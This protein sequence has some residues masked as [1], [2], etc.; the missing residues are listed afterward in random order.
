MYNQATDSPAID[1][2]SFRYLFPE[3]AR[4]STW[5]LDNWESQHQ[6]PDIMKKQADED[7][8]H[9][10]EQ[11]MM[12]KNTSQDLH[13]RLIMALFQTHFPASITPRTMYGLHSAY[14][15]PRSYYQLQFLLHREQ[16]GV[17]HLQHINMENWNLCTTTPEEQ[18]L[19]QLPN[20]D[21]LIIKTNFAIYNKLYNLFRKSIYALEVG[22]FFSSF[23]HSAKLYGLECQFRVLNNHFVIFFQ[24]NNQLNDVSESLNEWMDIG[25]KR[26]SGHF[27]YGLF[28][29]KFELTEKLVSEVGLQIQQAIDKVQQ[30]HPCIADIPISLKACFREFGS[31]SAGLYQLADGQF[32]HLDSGEYVDQAASTYSYDNFCLNSVPSMLFLSIPTEVFRR[33]I[34]VFMTI[35]V[36]LGSIY[37]DLVH[38]LIPKGLFGRPFRSYDQIRIDELIHPNDSE[39][40]TYYGMMIGKNRGIETLGVIK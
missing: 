6:F 29:A 10:A 17:R 16:D 5:P 36:A 18:S 22:H 35:N 7:F 40:T 19:T 15:S 20:A 34:D 27:N 8:S 26:N 12:G 21:C 3:K 9:L 39:V 14:P 24:R 30:Q 1:E 32:K 31:H 11:C 23:Q 25:R 37:Q 28:P 33:D 2:F 38:L 4:Q 13:D